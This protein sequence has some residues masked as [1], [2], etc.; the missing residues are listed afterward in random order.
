MH[1]HFF[2]FWIH[3]MHNTSTPEPL[4]AGGK[5]QTQK[6]LFCW[7]PAE[8]SGMFRVSPGAK[9]CKGWLNWSPQEA[10]RTTQ[11]AR[12][13]SKNKTRELPGSLFP[14]QDTGSDFLSPLTSCKSTKGWRRSPQAWFGDGLCISVHSQSLMSQ[15]TNTENLWGEG[16]D[17]SEHT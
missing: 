8:L 2:P 12:K 7:V 11:W 9:S 17:K 10:A 1:L 6:H 4:V 5:T 14:I 16:C 3:D 15:V 13:Y